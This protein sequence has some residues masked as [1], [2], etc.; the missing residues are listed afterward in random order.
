MGGRIKRL[1]ARIW[2]YPFWFAVNRAGVAKIVAEDVD[3]AVRCTNNAEISA[4]DRYSQFAF[5]C[6][7]ELERQFRTLVHYRLQSAPPFVR[8]LLR[9]IYRRPA[10]PVLQADRIGPGLFIQHGDDTIVQAQSIGSYCW[11]NQ[12]VTVGATAEGRPT[13]G[14]RV[15][16]GTGAVVVGPVTLHD[17]ATIGPNATVIHDIGPGETVVAPAAVPV[18]L[19]QDGDA[20]R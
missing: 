20:R 5:L 11:I 9:A 10:T 13:L 4:L 7:A 15:R 14:D 19:P 17:G 18:E 16:I 8:L 2:A 1:L 6:S 3:W 12:N